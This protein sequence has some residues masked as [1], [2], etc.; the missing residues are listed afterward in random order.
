MRTR[1]ILIQASHAGNVG[2]AAR[3]IKTMGFGDL[4]LVA[5]R[6]ANVLRREETIQRASGALDVLASARIVETL[7]EA[8]DGVTHLCATAMVPRDFG[9]PTLNPRE[10]LGALAR[11][12]ERHVAFLF[13]SERFGMRNED[14]YRC[15]VALSIPTDPRFGSLNLGAA[16]QVIAYEWRQALGGFAVRDAAAPPRAADAQMVA[17]M[18]AHWE[19]ALVQIGFL[20]P[21]APK[22]LM[23]RLRQLFNRAQP[24]REEIH[25]LRGIAKAMADARGQRKPD[26]R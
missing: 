12:A 18:L 17:G 1:F 24:T 8:L 4:V 26:D 19:Q 11:G 7:D 14:V 10:H 20:D 5:P 21:R 3:A 25:I 2:A 9:P 23:P 13:G 6:W 16:I 15:H 22:K